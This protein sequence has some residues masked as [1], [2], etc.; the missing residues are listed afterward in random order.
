MKEN[1]QLT[2]IPYYIGPT[3]TAGQQKY[4]WRYTVRLESLDRKPAV[5]RERVL[6]VFSL[7]NLQQVNGPGVD[8]GVS[9]G[10]KSRFTSSNF[11]FIEPTINC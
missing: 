5:L 11:F 3:F 7:N 9:F 6:K 8:G 4:F 10:L 1:I 2:V